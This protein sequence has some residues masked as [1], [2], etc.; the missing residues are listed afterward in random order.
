MD[1]LELLK[2]EIEALR[3]ENRR[4]SS[5]VESARLH[6]AR[7]LRLARAVKASNRWRVGNAVGETIRRARRLGPPDLPLDEL[8]AVAE[9]FS[10]IGTRGMPDETYARI[11]Y[12]YE[13]VRERWRVDAERESR[14]LSRTNGL[15]KRFKPLKVL[16]GTMFAGENELEQ[17]KRSVERQ[18]HPK[19]ETI[20]IEG[21]S[22]KD[23]TAELMRRFRESDADLLLKL[24]ADMV[25]VDEDFVA[26]VSDTFSAN[27]DL[28]VLNMALLD[29][30]SGDLMQGINA[31]RRGFE[32][33]NRKQDALFTDRMSGADG[34]RWVTWTT[35]ANSVLHCPNPSEFQAFHFGFHRGMKV[36]QLDRDAVDLSAATE[37]FMYLAKTREHYALRRDRRLA[38]ALLG[39]EIALTE[40]IGLE[41]IS[42]S[43]PTMKR[44]FVPFQSLS[45]QE[46]DE[47]IEKR[48][49]LPALRREAEELRTNRVEILEQQ[50]R[51]V[52]RVVAALPHIDFFGG[53]HRFFELA[54]AF[55][56]WGVELI[57]AVP[58]EE[59]V[60]TEGR[61]DHRADYADVQVLKFSDALRQSWDVVMCGD[62]SSGV[63]LTLPWFDARLSVAYILNGWRDR[64]YNCRQ[65]CAVLPDLVV[66]NSS[67]AGSQY[68]DLAPTCVPGGIN[69]EA[70]NPSVAQIRTS[71][72]LR[73]G[74]YPGR[75][76]PHKRFEDAKRALELVHRS[77][78]LELHYYD[79]SKR[80]VDAPFPVVA[81]GPLDRRQV[82]SFL[83]S[84]DVM[85]CP[86]EDAGWSNP[87]A[88]ALACGIPLICTP[89]GT[90]DF[91]VDGETAFVVQP[92]DPKAIARALERVS[93]DRGRAARLARAGAER[94]G[95]FSWETVARKLIDAF[96]LARKDR[97]SRIERNHRAQRLVQNLGI[98]V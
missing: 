86:E 64:V 59:L 49:G 66:A 68:V 87:A 18:S 57:V 80:E 65:I 81:H 41:N 48:R 17:C 34:H 42:Y 36:V 82:T 20:F 83:S 2:A 3:Q 53:V 56:K 9:R 63:M 43:D 29:F 7:I 38:F 61:P 78:P 47:E 27:E 8:I 16:A 98:S 15:P 35:F 85:V 67:Y 46:L 52:R 77:V 88:E 32:W 97:A 25:L 30:F 71:G 28:V 94:M 96:R 23:A 14:R 84:I 50:T 37:Q 75:F 11:L 31:Y 44:R 40:P 73:V 51:D 12:S 13:S 6:V 21:L 74:V 93:R 92:R 90:T 26:D 10:V 54:R 70:F 69:L 24:D 76:K 89:A 4:L 72:R 5:H 62:M 95:D 39:F 22:E 60:G 45:L 55:A 33:D 1:T 58:D 91:A 79:R 19:I